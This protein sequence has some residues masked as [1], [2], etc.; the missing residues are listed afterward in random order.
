MIKNTKAKK[1]GKNKEKTRESRNVIVKAF[2][3]AYLKECVSN[4]YKVGNLFVFPTI[5]KD[6]EH[7]GSEI[8][9]NIK[10]GI[11]R[12]INSD[13]SVYQSIRKEDSSANKGYLN[14]IMYTPYVEDVHGEPDRYTHIINGE[15]VSRDWRVYEH[16]IGALIGAKLSGEDIGLTLNYNVNHKDGCPFHNEVDN[17]EFISVRENNYH[18]A[19]I[20]S[21]FY[22]TDSLFHIG[23]DYNSVKNWTFL[24]YRL[25][26]KDVVKY[27]AESPTFREQ[28]ENCARTLRYKDMANEYIDESVLR[29]FKDYL[30]I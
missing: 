12:R 23:I 2:N 22:N 11:P 7:N 5:G 1:R 26:A 3:I 18:G 29:R 9:Y 24:L 30:D 13:G 15:P 25:S 6:G 21:I 19:V 4:G 14:F 27:M 8:E 17:L 20:N 28:V 16:I 10:T